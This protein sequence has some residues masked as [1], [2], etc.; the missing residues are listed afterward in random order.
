METLEAQVEK[1]DTE[2]TEVDQRIAELTT[3]AEPVLERLGKGYGAVQQR[4][5]LQLP[6]DEELLAALKSEQLQASRP[7][8]GVQKLQEGEQPLCPPP[9]QLTNT[10]LAQLTNTRPASATPCSALYSAVVIDMGKSLSYVESEAIMLEQVREKRVSLLRRRACDSPVDCQRLGPP[11]A[12]QSYPFSGRARTKHGRGTSSCCWGT[13]TTQRSS[14]TALCSE[15]RASP[16]ARPCR[17]APASIGNV[18][19]WRGRPWRR[20]RASSRSPSRSPGKQN[21]SPYPNDKH[22]PRPTDK[23]APPVPGRLSEGEPPAAAGWF[24]SKIKK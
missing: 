22:T 4:R 23:I 6:R 21:G 14:R 2:K 20:R 17:T 15:H 10:R 24:R 12:P 7:E 18:L 3:D 19:P 1:M 16:T 9:A 11:T 13:A 5:K 8:Q